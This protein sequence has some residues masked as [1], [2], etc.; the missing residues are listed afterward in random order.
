MRACPSRSSKRRPQASRSITTRV[1]SAGEVVVDG[2]TG[3]LTDIDTRALTEATARLLAD[4]S[5]RRAMGNAARAHFDQHFAAGRLVRDVTA[6]YEEL[7]A[8]L[9]LP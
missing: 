9:H 3:F 6:L 1:G 4:E 5:L 2:V 7:A 8:E